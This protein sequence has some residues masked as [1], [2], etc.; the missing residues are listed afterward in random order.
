MAKPKSS[1]LTT[2]AAYKLTGGVWTKGCYE[3][4]YTAEVIALKVSITFANIC[5]NIYIVI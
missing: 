2:Q 5:V 4:E 3:R 1:S